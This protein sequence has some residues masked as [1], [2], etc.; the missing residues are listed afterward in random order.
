[1]TS[2][3][4]S[5]A[6]EDAVRVAAPDGSHVDILADCPAGSMARFSLAPGLTSKAVR[7]RTVHELWY[8]IAGTGEM[9][10][11]N[12]AQEAVLHIAAGMSLAIPPQTAFQ[13]RSTGSVVLEAIGVTMPPWPGL[14]EAEFVTGKWPS[15]PFR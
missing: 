10:L 8:V 3:F 7:H 5:V 4:R 12:G 13:F 14:D 2:S 15:S 11:N 1:M 6:I 9:W